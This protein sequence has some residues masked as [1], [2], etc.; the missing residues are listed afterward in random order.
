[1]L[2]M[3]LSLPTEKLKKS[4]W[5]P[6]NVWGRGQYHATPSPDIIG[7]MNAASP[8]I[9]PVPLFY[10]HLQ[11]DLSEALRKAGQDYDA[12]LCLLEDSK[13]E[14]V[15]CQSLSTPGE[16]KQTSLTTHFSSDGIAGVVRGIPIPFRDL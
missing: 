6:G 1:M 10:R 3:E 9:P 14:L 16:P 4:G 15:W 13:E 7:K 8:V 2:T 5:S 12:R 11:M